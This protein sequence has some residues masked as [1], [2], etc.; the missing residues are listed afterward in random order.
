MAGCE[1]SVD[2]VSG[3]EKEAGSSMNFSKTSWRAKLSFRFFLRAFPCFITS[4]RSFGEL[5]GL[6]P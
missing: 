3:T 1:T 6:L 4:L 5:K 2:V